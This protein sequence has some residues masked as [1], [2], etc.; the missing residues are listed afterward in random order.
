MKPICFCIPRQTDS[1]RY[2]ARQ[3]GQWGFDIRPDAGPDT[4][5][6]LL[7]IPSGDT[8]LPQGLP[9]KAVLF[10]G[11]KLNTALPCIDLLRDEEFLAQNAA[12][13]AHCAAVLAM[14]QLPITLDGCP[15]LV[16]GWGRIGKCLAKLLH[17]LGAAVTVAARSSRDRAMLTALGYPSIPVDG[18][19]AADYRLIIN[20]VPAPVLGAEF[21][22]DALQLDLASSPGILSPQAIHARG[23]PGR[24]APESAGILIARTI[25]RYLEGEGL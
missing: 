2:A 23:L 5:H 10:C 15:A 1:I 14:E 22:G 12:I 8:Q 7:P 17:A 16:I 4:T 3:L 24:F 6:V 11:G 21:A 13:T 18:I 19:M 20:T 9:E 25:L